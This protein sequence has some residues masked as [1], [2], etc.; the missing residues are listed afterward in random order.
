MTTYIIHVEDA[1]DYSCHAR[2][3][4]F[5]DGYDGAP[6]DNE[7]PSDDPL[8]TGNTKMEAI[9]NLIE[10]ALDKGKEE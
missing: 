2:Y 5:F 1:D 3:H 4:A 8:G 7:T 10:C 9:Y 6:I